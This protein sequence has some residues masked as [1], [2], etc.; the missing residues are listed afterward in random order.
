[1]KSTKINIGENNHGYIINEYQEKFQIINYLYETLEPE[2][3]STKFIESENDLL[4][5]KNN[6]YHV[7]PHFVGGKYLLLFKSIKECDYC[8]LI[9]KSSLRESTAD[10]NYNN[11]KIISIKLRTKPITYSGTIFDG[12][13]INVKGKNMFIINNSYYLGGK[14]ILEYTLEE[15]YTLID[16]Y[17]EDNIINDNHMN[18]IIKPVLN[19]LSSYDDLKELVYNKIK[20]SP[21]PINGIIF[22]SDRVDINYVFIENVS[23]T[24]DDK[25]YATFQ[26][27]KTPITDVYDL[28]LDTNKDIARYGIAHVP[29]IKC[30]H[31]C[32][33]L[34]KNKKR[35]DIILVDCYYSHKFKK[36][37][38]E[39]ISKNQLDNVTDVRNKIK[40]AIY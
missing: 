30:S 24:N 10:I 28:F 7:L 6:K 21:L 1:M 40:V 16:N 29:S 13:L 32:L 14:N 11:I 37:I 19:Q 17:I 2:I 33:D 3:Y 27:R 22:V 18:N 12:T 23:I 39:I 38:P 36:W 26:I 4:E 5:L 20:K 9:N 25:I 15:R 34:F 31:F 8:V 35:H